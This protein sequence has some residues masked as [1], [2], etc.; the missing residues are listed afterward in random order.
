MILIIKVGP[1]YTGE[2]LPGDK[3]KD[4]AAETPDMKGIADS[5]DKNQLGCS[6]TEWSNGLCWRGR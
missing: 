5:S 1:R 3:L 4:K 6:K 2:W